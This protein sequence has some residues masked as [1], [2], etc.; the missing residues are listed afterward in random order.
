MENEQI[1][2]R[3][4]ALRPSG[5]GYGSGYGSGSGSGYGSGSGDGYGYGYGDGYGDG[6]GVKEINGQHVYNVDGV[7][8]IFESIHGNYA[9]AFILKSDLTLKPCWVAKYEDYFAHGETLREAQADAHMKALK[10]MSTEERL[11]AFIEAH[12]DTEHRYPAADLFEW[13]GIL[14]GS[15][16]MGRRHFCQEHNIN[17]ETDTFTIEEFIQLTKNNFGGDIIMKISYK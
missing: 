3:F 8:T 11:T 2:A 13:H 9:K 16:N 12:P 6:D 17:V 14:T 5:S 10:E 1:I 7:P 15:C 4:L